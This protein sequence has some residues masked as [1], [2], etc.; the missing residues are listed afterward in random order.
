MDKQLKT[1]L[2]SILKGIKVDT[3]NEVIDFIES[4]FQPKSDDNE[5]ENELR[6]KVEHIAHLESRLNDEIEKNNQ[7]TQIIQSLTRRK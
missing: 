7:K 5:L 3:K 2:N 4:N 1:Q 6:V